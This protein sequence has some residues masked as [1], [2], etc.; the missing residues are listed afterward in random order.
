MLNKFFS[1]LGG[2]IKKKKKRTIFF[3]RSEVYIYI[4]IYIY[5]I[6]TRYYGEAPYKEKSKI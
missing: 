4:Y 1:F 2:D 6:Y 3:Y 5:C